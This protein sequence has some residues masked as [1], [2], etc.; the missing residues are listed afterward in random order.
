MQR[1]GENQQRIA[2][3]LLMAAGQ[4][5]LLSYWLTVVINVIGH[6]LVALQRP[7]RIAF[8]LRFYNIL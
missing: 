7:V 2:M 1:L 5:C 8:L 4:F 6:F 3:Y